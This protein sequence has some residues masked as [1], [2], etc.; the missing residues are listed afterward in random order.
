M[1]TGKGKKEDGRE[2]RERKQ[3]GENQRKGKTMKEVRW[4]GKR[5]EKENERKRTLCKWKWVR[6]IGTR[7]RCKREND[8]E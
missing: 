4:K 8:Y 6:K 1:K 7:K 5:Y 2:R 3:G